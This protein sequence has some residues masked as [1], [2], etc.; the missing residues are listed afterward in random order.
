LQDGVAIP[1]GDGTAALVQ[2][3][4][5]LGES[6]FKLLLRERPVAEFRVVSGEGQ[7][8]ECVPIGPVVFLAVLAQFALSSRREVVVLQHDLF[9][10]ILFNDD[11]FLAVV[12]LPWVCISIARPSA[13]RAPRAAALPPRPR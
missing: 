3:D 1:R 4:R 10:G 13:Q 9:D 7:I 11:P 2:I 8:P 12:I 6:A 5:T